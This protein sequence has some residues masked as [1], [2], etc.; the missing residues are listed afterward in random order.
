MVISWNEIDE[1]TYVVPLERYG[2]QSLLTLSSIIHQPDRSQRMNRVTVVLVGVAAAV[3]LAVTIATHLLAL[4]QPAGAQD[5]RRGPGDP[6]QFGRE[7]VGLIGGSGATST[8]GSTA[9][10]YTPGTAP[11]LSGC[12]VS[13]SNPSP[14]QGQTAET[15]TVTTNPDVQVS[16]VAGYAHTTSRHGGV[17]SPAGLISFSLPVQH[18]PVGVAVNVTATASLRAQKVNCTT[19]FTPVP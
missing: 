7:G 2:A 1:G 13:V 3:T 9:P 18:A 15:V 11:T 16:V 8:T 10:G 12:S 14:R 6:R 17:S 19:A 5:P 4:E